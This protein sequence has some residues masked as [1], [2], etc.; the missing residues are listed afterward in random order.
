MQQ[1]FSEK[2]TEDPPDEVANAELLLAAFMAEHGMPFSQADHLTELVK[3]MF[4]KCDDAQ[5][6]AMK[7]T[8]ALYVMQEGIAL[9]ESKKIAKICRENKFSL[10]IEESTDV[11]VSQVLAVMVRFFDKSKCKV[12]D[13]LLDIVE[14]D[15]PS[16]EGL[17][18]AVKELFARKE[19]PLT[20]LIG[21]ACDNC[22][23]MMGVNNGFQ[24]LLKKRPSISVRS[25]VHLSFICTMFKLCL[26]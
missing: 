9:E 18:K 4:P 15:D 6:I 5:K 2:K 13:A 22:S 11:S 12:T 24:A 8:K 1:F 20:N 23:T 21:L 7:K 14:V 3:K 10:M 17:Y 25:W 26:C 16:A 19:I